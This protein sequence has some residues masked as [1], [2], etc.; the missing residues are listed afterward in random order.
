M[1]LS[2][3]HCTWPLKWLAFTQVGKL[4]FR[5]HQNINCCGANNCLLECKRVMETQAQFCFSSLR[6]CTNH[7]RYQLR[8]STLCNC[9]GDPADCNPFQKCNFI[10][11]PSSLNRNLWNYQGVPEKTICLTVFFF[12]IPELQ[13][14]FA[15][16]CLMLASINST[17]PIYLLPCN[18]V[19]LTNKDNGRP[20]ESDLQVL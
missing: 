1:K 20:K 17:Q 9:V 3:T 19:P 14:Q 2:P 10:N 15:W 13:L 4:A 5:W 8:P 11:F 18:L 12:Y 16:N 6:N 7:N